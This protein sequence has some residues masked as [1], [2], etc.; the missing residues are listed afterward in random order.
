MSLRLNE[1]AVPDPPEIEEDPM[2]LEE[3][4]LQ[5]DLE[6]PDPPDLDRLAETQPE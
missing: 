4:D 1:E 2:P 3:L 6:V 5:E